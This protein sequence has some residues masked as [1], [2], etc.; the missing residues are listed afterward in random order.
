MHISLFYL[1]A[2]L[3][4]GLNAFGKRTTGT[5]VC[6]NRALERC[7]ISK[8]VPF[9]VPC[10]SDWEGYSKTHNI[11]LPVTPAAIALPDNSRH[12][13]AAV[14]CAGR[15]GIKVQA[16]SGGLRTDSYGSYSSGGIDGQVMIDL[17]NFNETVLTN[18]ADIAVVGGGIRLGPMAKAIYEQG[19]RA[20]S[21]GICS[22]VGIGG[23]ST[24]GGW[25]Y[26]SRAWG[27]TLD[28]IV[29]MQVVLAN[30]TVTQASPDLNPD[31]YW[32]MR[33]AAD[34]IGIAISIS[35]KTQ[36]APKEVVTFIYELQTVVKS[37]QK[38]VSALMGLQNYISNP[39]AVDRRLSLSVTTTV[40]PDPVSGA[41]N[42][43]LV[44]AG[45]FMGSLGEFTTRIEP[46]L[47]RHVPDAPT[48]R[49]VQSH[50]WIN[51]LMRQS[52][53]GSLEGT[54]ES[55][56]FFANSVTINDPGLTEAATTSYFSYM[57]EGPAPP[58]VAFESSMELWGGADG[59]IGLAA[60]NVS[61]A[62]FP[63]RRVFWTA[64]NLAQ[65]PPGVPFPDEG[66]AFMNGL[67]E[68]ITRGLD[69]PT[70]AYPNLLDTSLT[71]EEAHALYY[72]EE[73]LERLRRVKAAYDPKNVFSNPQSI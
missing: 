47:L 51:S 8:G 12:V 55:L 67:R 31:L 72:G 16:K 38:S 52:P 46:E 9:K 59:Q 44:V 19:N 35:L 11:R 54:P 32:A 27:L 4:L 57:L 18:G 58:P 25:G 7:L 21:H 10:S 60:K 14:V 23:H 69:V 66:I 61:F 48:A 65:P 43:S 29:A 49:E 3:A 68:A 53:D 56:D 73:V 26:T 36:P 71:R 13:S 2:T 37:V 5:R 45:I 42:K 63:H 62:A 70:G 1:A 15:S 33:G 24:H 30:G 28:H 6:S 40:I 50:N 17:R 20:V 34:S 64:N 39:T 22:S 41:V